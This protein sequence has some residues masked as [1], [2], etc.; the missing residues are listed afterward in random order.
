MIFHAT[1]RYEAEELQQLENF[2]KYIKD[3]NLALPAG[4]DDDERMI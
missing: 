4:Y 2:R 1:M 3:N